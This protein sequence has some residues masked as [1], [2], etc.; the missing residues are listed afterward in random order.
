MTWPPD[1]P[2]PEAVRRFVTASLR[3]GR[4]FLG[5]GYQAP[6]YVWRES[7]PPLVI[8]VASGCFPLRAL[9]RWMLRREYRAYRHLAGLPA[10]PRCFGLLDRR[11]LVLEYVPGVPRHT[12]VIA[13]RETFFAE[14]FAAIAA[15]HR[16]GVAHGDLQ[17]RDN[18][19]VVDGRHPAIVDF[20]TA[21]VRREGFAPLNHWLFRFLS[22]LDCNT[23][24][25]LKYDGRLAHAS[26]AD[27]AHYHR[28][29]LERAAHRVKR[30]YT[31][32]RRWWRRRQTRSRQQA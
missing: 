22:R 8:K 10:V 12:A 6:L 1:A 4:N 29:W 21:V 5:H 30:T 26:P 17:K 24:V 25:K 16:R 32:P 19:L 28:T 13:D 20:G 15:M 23:W 27:L 14:L 9:R 11:Y 7:T 31:A 18:L 3:Q 2:P